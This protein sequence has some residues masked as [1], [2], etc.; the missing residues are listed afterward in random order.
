M[1]TQAP[2]SPTSETIVLDKNCHIDISLDKS[3]CTFLPLKGKYSVSCF[4]LLIQGVTKCTKHNFILFHHTHTHT[5]D[6][7]FPRG[8]IQY[9][10]S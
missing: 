2:E 7:T 4:V 10:L 9:I 3:N 1:D 8:N 6:I 5:Q